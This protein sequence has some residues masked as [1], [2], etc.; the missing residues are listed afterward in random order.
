MAKTSIIIEDNTIQAKTPEG[1]VYKM[2]VNGFLDKLN[3]YEFSLSKTI[4]PDGVRAIHTVGGVTVWV[5]ERPPHIA[6]YKWIA[7]DSPSQYGA[8]TKY[9]FVKIA[10]PYTVICA[11]FTQDNT[12]LGQC[13][14]FFRND[15]ISDLTDEL[16]YPAFLNC[17]KFQNNPI[18]T[19]MQALSWICTQHVNYEGLPKNEE[20]RPLF[21]LEK[22]K[23]CLFETGFNLSSEGHEG[24]SWYGESSKVV[25]EI[26]TV[27]KWEEITAQKIKQGEG[28]I[29]I[30]ECDWIPAKITVEEVIARLMRI[31]GATKKSFKSAQDLLGLF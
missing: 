30:T 6:N 19:G 24:A 21:L 10:V 1:Q 9:R 20:D 8:G 12:R 31:H 17:S 3:S 11:T 5:Y 13:E 22:L 28:G 27:E 14:C 18:K 29:W 15:P 16:Y 7:A 23:S 25:K 2:P 26:S 4:I